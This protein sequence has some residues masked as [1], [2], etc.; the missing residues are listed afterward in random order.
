MAIYHHLRRI[1]IMEK[2]KNITVV[3]STGKKVEFEFQKQMNS[4]SYEGELTEDE[5]HELESIK[6]R[7]S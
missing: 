1:N 3:L 6:L 4:C 5:S 2:A 7:L